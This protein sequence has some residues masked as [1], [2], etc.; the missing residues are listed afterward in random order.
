MTVAH[1]ILAQLGGNRFLAMT[2][3]RD[4]LRDEASLMFGLPRFKGLK[5]NKVR[6]TLRDSDAYTI[7]FMR[8]WKPRGDFVPT[9]DTLET[10][11]GVHAEDLARIFTDRTELETRL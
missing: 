6:I 9:V 11:E 7:E 2:G 8:L 10:I 3:A 5:I 1:T 4:M